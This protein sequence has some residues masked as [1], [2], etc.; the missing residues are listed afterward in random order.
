M[1]AAR[2]VAVTAAARP[3][4]EAVLARLAAFR[5][6]LRDAGMVAGLG[7]SEDAARLLSLGLGAEPET[8]RPA[9]K[10]LFCSRKSDWDTFDSLF[11]AFWLGRG[12]RSRTRVVGLPA[13]ANA[14]TLPSLAAPRHQNTAATE[15]GETRARRDPT[16]NDPENA[17]GRGRMEGASRF[18]T[19]ARTDFRKIADPA[20][21]AEA[22]TIA[23]QLARR[24]RARITRRTRASRRPGPIDLRRT[25]HRNIAHGGELI[26]LVHR[27]RKPKPLRL[28]LLLDTSGSMSLYTSVFIRFMHGVLD[29][30]READAFL[31]HTR[32]VQV[33]DAMREKDGTRAL[34][35]L[36]LMTE[37]VGGGT[38]IGESLATFNRWHAAR[39][40]HSRSCLMIVSDGYDT[41]EPAALATELARL[42]RR[43]RHIVWLNPMLGWVGYEP[44]ARGMQTALPFID[45]LAPAHDLASLAA[46]EPYLSRI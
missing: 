43:C 18:A 33:S 1:A 17:D 9:F 14:P 34:E 27:A 38:R 35:R 23:E 36:S 29:H 15:L 6:T 11:D 30:F 28:V 5:H 41:G 26:E 8:L 37:G 32:L 22:H 39:V 45:L 21:L 3:P 42:R 25:I 44:S 46:L 13:P 19:L 40:L 2:N 31:F 4:G 12:V 24:M 16:G 10:A 7:E 20:L